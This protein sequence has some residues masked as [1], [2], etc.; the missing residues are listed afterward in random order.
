MIDLYCLGYERSFSNKINRHF[1]LIFWV[2]IGFSLF[3]KIVE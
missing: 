3:L 2:L 1:P